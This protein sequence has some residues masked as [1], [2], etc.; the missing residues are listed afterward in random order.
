M[1]QIV[2]LTTAM[3]SA[4]KNLIP[5]E[6]KEFCDAMR[7]QYIFNCGNNNE[8]LGYKSMSRQCLELQ[9]IDSLVTYTTGEFLVSQTF[10]F[11]YLLDNFVLIPLNCS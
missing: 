1:G 6:G 4:R 9:D 11:F 2:N 3:E 5:F 8:A 7:E 10:R